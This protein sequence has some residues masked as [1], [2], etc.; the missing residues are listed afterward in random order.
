MRS[1]KLFGGMVLSLAF[2]AG[3]VAAV[4]SLVD[5]MLL[6]QRSAAAPEHLLVLWEDAIQRGGSARTNVSSANFL[7]WRERSKSFLHV[8]AA[9]NITLSLVQGSG[10][11]NSLLAH[12]V[13]A[14]YFEALGRVA[15]A[16]KKF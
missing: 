6:Q 4:F 11:P 14:N 3:V 9:R 13:T 15:I 16:R 2:G 1:P 10:E 12:S 8:A 7:E 5:A